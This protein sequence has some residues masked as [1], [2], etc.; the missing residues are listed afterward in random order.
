[1]LK[2]HI[3]DYLQAQMFQMRTGKLSSNQMKI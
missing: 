3:I 2:K 1:M